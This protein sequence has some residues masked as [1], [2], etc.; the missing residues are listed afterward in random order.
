MNDYKKLLR[1]TESLVIFRSLHENK[2]FESSLSTLRAVEEGKTDK[3][4]K[5]YCEFVAKLYEN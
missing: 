4:I 3:S 2:V 1:Q 5:K